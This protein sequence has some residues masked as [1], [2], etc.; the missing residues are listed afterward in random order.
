MTDYERLERWADRVAEFLYDDKSNDWS[1]E[2]REYEAIFNLP[3][4]PDLT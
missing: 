1:E 4:V 2:L 3:P